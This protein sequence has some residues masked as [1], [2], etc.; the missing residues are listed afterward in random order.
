MEHEWGDE[1]RIEKS[2]SK[3][4]TRKSKTLMGG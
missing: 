2:Q 1:E 3:E 4:T